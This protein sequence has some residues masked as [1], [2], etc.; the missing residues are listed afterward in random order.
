MNQEYFLLKQDGQVWSGSTPY[1][2]Q[3]VIP[4]VFSPPH[5]LAWFENQLHALTEQGDLYRLSHTPL[6]GKNTPHFLTTKGALT[7]F[8]SSQK[9]AVFIMRN[10]ETFTWGSNTFGQCGISPTCEAYLDIPLKVLSDVKHCVCWDTGTAFI[11][12]DN[13][14]YAGRVATVDHPL[15]A[16]LK[17]LQ[18]FDMNMDIDTDIDTKV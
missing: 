10:G 14:F 18:V 13:V 17:P 6:E 7:D 5:N 9:H 11:T 12:S 3:I 2:A 16:T 8:A 4:K 1:A 15:A